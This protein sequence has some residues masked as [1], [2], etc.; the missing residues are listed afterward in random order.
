MNF[1]FDETELSNSLSTGTK[2]IMSPL[3]SDTLYIAQSIKSIFV[4]MNEFQTT[5]ILFHLPLH[6]QKSI[7]L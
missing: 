6:I 4:G 5:S 7:A 2:L 1:L 3:T